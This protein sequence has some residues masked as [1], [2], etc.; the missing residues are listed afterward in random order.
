MEKLA[1]ACVLRD[2]ALTTW[3]VGVLV[4]LTQSMANF[5]I[6]MKF[7]NASLRNNH[8]THIRI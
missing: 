2:T 5:R 1:R 4:E 3:N 7:E 8:K 6:W